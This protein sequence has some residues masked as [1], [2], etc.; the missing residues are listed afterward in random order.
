MIVGGPGSG[1]STAA[2]ALGAATGLPVYHMDH[3]HWQARWIERSKSEKDA[4]TRSIHAKESWIFEGNHS[5]TYAERVSRA[6]TLI[7][8][9]LPLALRLYRVVWRTIRDLGK[10]R[11]DLPE[12]CP[13]QL[14]M[15]TLKFLHFIWRTRHSAPA[16]VRQQVETAKGNITVIHLRSR[17]EVRDYLAG[18]SA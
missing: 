1:K 16:K 17:A 7:W 18:L 10:Q 5:N 11:P 13:E 15:E 9:D 12:G 3:I 2:R 14:S 6:D 4:L 8:L